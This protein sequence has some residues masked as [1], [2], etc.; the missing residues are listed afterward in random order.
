MKYLSLAYGSEDGWNRLTAVEN[1]KSLL[2]I[3]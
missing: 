3:L 1:E 2:K